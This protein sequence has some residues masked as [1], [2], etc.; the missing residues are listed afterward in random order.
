[1]YPRGQVRRRC[2]CFGLTGVCLLVLFGTSHARADSLLPAV[3]PLHKFVFGQLVLLQSGN[4]LN[5]DDFGKYSLEESFAPDGVASVSFSTFGEPLPYVFAQGASAVPHK[6]GRTLGTLIYE[7]EVLGPEVILPDGSIAPV[8]VV[9]DAFGHAFASA[10]EE[11]TVDVHATW[12]LTDA[13]LNFAPVFE[14]GVHANQNLAEDSFNHSVL[15]SLTPNHVFRVTLFADV[16]FNS[17]KFGAVGQAYMDPLFYF[18][19]QVGPEYSF[20]FADGIGNSAVSV[21]EPGSVLLLST[22][23]AAIGLLRRRSRLRRDGTPG[24]LVQ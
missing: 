10:S 3:A 13:S 11:G 17:G 23:A 24:M 2:F 18:A 9:A 21:P 4:G 5:F 20:R 16:F 15:L 1:M 14:E 22:G 7:F 6:S 12:S 8:Q 19:P